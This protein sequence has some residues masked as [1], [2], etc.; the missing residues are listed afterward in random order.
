MLRLFKILSVGFLI[1]LFAVPAFAAVDDVNVTDT[2]DTLAIAPVKTYTDLNDE[3]GN[4]SDFLILNDTYRFDMACDEALIDGVRIVKNI[5]L[6]GNGEAAIDGSNLARGLYI[7][8]HCNVVLKNIVFKNCYSENSG[9]GIFLDK[10]SNLTVSNSIFTN[11]TVY[12][13]DGGVINGEYYTN[14]EIHD[15]EFYNN[16]SMRVSALPWEDFK[17]GMGSA[18]CT[19]VG[20]NLKLYN[21]VFKQN[22]AYLTTVLV[23]TFDD[24]GR[25]LSTLYVKNCTFEN[26][27]S[28]S[29]GVIYLD[30]F[31][32]GEIY[33]ST[34][35]NNVVTKRSGTLVL[36]ASVWGIVKNCLFEG[37]SANKGGAIYIKLYENNYVANISIIDCNFTRN[38][39]TLY[40]GAIYTKGG[41]TR[42]YNSSFIENTAGDHGGAVA[43]LDGTL[44]I[45][46]STF[47]NNSS[48]TGGALCIK[49]DKVVLSNLTFINNTASKMGGAVY[50]S[51]KDVAISKLKYYANSAKASKNVYGVFFV[52]ITKIT[53]KSGKTKVRVTLTSPWKMPLSQKIKFTFNGRSTKWYRANSKG[54]LTFILS[55]KYKVTK[56]STKITMKSGIGVVKKVYKKTPL[57]I[58]APKKV[59]KKSKIMIK[60]KNQVNGKVI[61][62]VK[63]NVR[64]FT[65][66]NYMSVKIKST[67]NGNLK[68]ATKKLSRGKHKI[69]VSLDSKK[70]ELNKACTVKQVIGVKMIF[71]K[72]EEINTE[73]LIPRKDYERLQKVLNVHQIYLNNLLVYYDLKPTP[74]LERFRD[75]A[76]EFLR[77]FDNVCVKH[78]LKYWINYGTLLG[79]VRHGDFIPWDDNLDV[80]MMRKDYEKLAEILPDELNSIDILEISTERPLQINCLTGQLDDAIIGLNVFVH[81]FIDGEIGDDFKQQYDSLKSGENGLDEV[82]AKLGLTYDENEFYI[83][84]IEGIHGENDKF[85]LKIRQ[86]DELF[87]LKEIKFGKYVFPAPNDFHSYVKNIHGKGYTKIPKRKQDYK[88]LVSLREIDGIEEL[89]KMSCEDIKKVNDDYVF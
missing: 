55:K 48:P 47:T 74:F 76:Y 38:N 2:N 40:G 61:K 73:D 86:S 19:R 34:F 11:N 20:S 13:S 69:V 10:H 82:Y 87:P 56:K 4:A 49:S 64:I 44:K 58:V 37:N 22:R 41:I 42:I 51:T 65:G 12:N 33:D 14:V 29:S 78:G 36:D 84:G 60:V 68:I 53:Y 79:A 85:P 24:I 32:Q 66:K 75:L 71:N 9:G 23:I 72:K 25:S 7:G 67:S 31:G 17:K 5:T 18:I 63:F 88:R 16:T 27:T 35:R 81:D 77:F 21:S 46:N 1:L 54:K 15:C 89:L 52:K 45:Y 57:K 80:G 43:S 3:I 59:K 8:S 39:A 70:Y 6:V 28:T 30:E 26:N 83:P 50:S 62:K